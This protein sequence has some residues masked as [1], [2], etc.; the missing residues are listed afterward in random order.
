MWRLQSRDCGESSELRVSIFQRPAN[1]IRIL[2][3][4]PRHLMN[5]LIP[6]INAPHLYRAAEILD[7]RET[8]SRLTRGRPNVNHLLSSD[9][10]DVSRKKKEIDVRTRCLAKD[11]GRLCHG[12]GDLRAR[13]KR[14]NQLWPVAY[15][16]SPLKIRFYKSE[17]DEVR[18]SS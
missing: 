11:S 13:Q 10:F 17:R 8:S 7:D 18:H 12:I 6:A 4:L 14:E 5:Q 15:L 2:R 3:A 1:G 9:F 16:I